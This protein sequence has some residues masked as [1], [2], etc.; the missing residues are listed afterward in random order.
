MSNEVDFK[1]ESATRAEE[2][3][4]ARTIGT[5]QQE[6]T[7]ILNIY[8]PNVSAPKFIKQTLPSTKEQIGPDSIVVGDRNTPVSPT[9]RTSRHQIDQ[10][11]LELKNT[12]D[13]MDLVD[14]YRIFHPIAAFFSATHGTFSKI[15]HIS[16]HK[17][18][19][20]KYKKVEIIPC[21]LTGHNGIKL[22]INSQENYK[23]HSHSWT[24]NNTMLINGSP[25]K[26]RNS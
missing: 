25:K 20:N 2:G 4:Y 19:R 12:T 10:D 9:D 1:Q 23:N 24:L 15:D 6:D 7:A 11:S 17:A 14:I 16:G 22:K 8:A 5:I 3:Q 26:L 13:E 18:N 21:V